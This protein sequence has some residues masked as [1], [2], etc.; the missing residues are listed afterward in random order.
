VVACEALRK[1]IDP[2]PLPQ[3]AAGETPK[4]LRRDAA[5]AE[6]AAAA[7]AAGG[8]SPLGS[9]EQAADI[10]PVLGGAAPA[11][12]PPQHTHSKL[13][14]LERRRSTDLSLDSRL[15]R[16]VRVRLKLRVRSGTALGSTVAA[17][18]S[19][20]AATAEV[21]EVTRDSVSRL[22]AAAH[23]GADGAR[24]GA[25]AST[26]AAAMGADAGG[27]AR[28]DAGEIG[29]IVIEIEALELAGKQRLPCRN[30]E[31]AID[32][33]GLLKPA[34][35]TRVLSVR[36]NVGVPVP[37]ELRCATPLPPGGAARKALAAALGTHS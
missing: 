14:G 31:L 36:G 13:P 6:A 8:A 18:L 7:V 32:V 37:L 20:D 11:G 17:R 30:V 12:A 10:T 9:G 28:G 1:K 24:D 4:S 3:E 15:A 26:A 34:P 2:P 16:H 33:L 5:E 25:S 29:E 35:R 23:G 22:A 19:V 21:E 27:G